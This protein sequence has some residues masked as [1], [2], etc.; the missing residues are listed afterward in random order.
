VYTEYIERRNYMVGALNKM[1]G[2]V[3]PLPGGAFYTIAQLP[4]DDAD[5]FSKWLL[6]EFEYNNQTVMLAPASG[7]YSRPEKGKHQVRIAYVLKKED[8]V[9]AMKCLEEALKVYPGRIE[10][11]EKKIGI[12]MG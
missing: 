1:E 9:N 11:T 3:C 7:F 10:V 12:N 2:V 8:L 5:E 6:S 4:V